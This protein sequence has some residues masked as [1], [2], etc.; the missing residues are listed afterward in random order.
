MNFTYGI[1]PQNNCNNRKN[2]IKI[3][4]NDQNPTK[5]TP[6]KILKNT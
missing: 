3:S 4:T 5:E 6:T 2:L 1:M